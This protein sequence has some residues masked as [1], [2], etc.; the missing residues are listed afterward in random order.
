MK[1]VVFVCVENACRSQLA[2][3]FGHLH[4]AE[5][6]EIYSAGSTPSGQVNPKAVATMAELGY[7]M[8]SHRSQGLGELPDIEFD[9]VITMGCGDNC[10]WLKGK[11]REDWAL[12]DPKHLSK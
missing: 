4:K 11:I 1:H 5:G 12:P 10:P 9:A 2:E 6:V 3:A 8:N 7:D